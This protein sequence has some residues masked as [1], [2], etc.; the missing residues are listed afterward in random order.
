MCPIA[1]ELPATYVVNYS[2]SDIVFGGEGAVTGD[3]FEH[4]FDAR[5]GHHLAPQP[6]SDGTNV[7]EQLGMGFTRLAFGAVDSD[8]TDFEVSAVALDVPLAVVR[9]DDANDGRSAYKAHLNPRA[10]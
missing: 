10:T 8:V 9:D 4:T 2:G 5:A 3:H 7:F 6:L 1:A